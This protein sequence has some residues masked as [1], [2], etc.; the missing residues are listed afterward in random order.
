MKF[1]SLILSGLMA[2]G[3]VQAQEIELGTPSFNGNG[4]DRYNTAVSLTPSGQGVSI[5]FD[6]FIVSSGGDPNSRFDVKNCNISIPVHIP[7]GYSV[8]VFSVDYRGFAV[9]PRW[10]HVGFSANYYFAGQAGK[11]SERVFEYPFE[12]DFLIRHQVRDGKFVWSRCGKDTTL[13]ADTHL[14]AKGNNYGDETQAGVDS[15]DVTGAIEYHLKFRRCNNNPPPRPPKPKPPKPEPPTPRPPKP[16]PPVPRPPKP[17]PPV[18]R[19]PKPKPPVPKPPAGPACEID[20]IM[21]KPTSPYF[22]VSELV[23]HSVQRNVNLPA[24][25]ANKTIKGKYG[26]T[27]MGNC[28]EL[29]RMDGGANPSFLIK[30]VAQCKNGKVDRKRS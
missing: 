25:P 13:R 24:A 15:I 27:I 26:Q 21:M 7:N 4:C 20:T 19:P 23:L 17:K 5:L 2:V 1:F 8:S 30:W 12:D 29:M 22:Y 28:S 11:A 9:V 14:R 3:I 6:E 18:P 10:G 16:R